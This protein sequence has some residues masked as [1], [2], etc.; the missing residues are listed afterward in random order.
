MDNYLILF[1][2]LVS[3][4]CQNRSSEQ[5]TDNVTDTRSTTVTTTTPSVTPDTLCYQQ[6]LDRDTTTLR[7]LLDGKLATGYLDVNPYQ[8]DRARGPLHGAVDANRIRVEWLRSGEGITQPYE[9]NLVQEGD[10]LSWWEG[11]FIERQGT[12]VLKEPGTGYQ[13]KLTKAE[14]SPTE[15]P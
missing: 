5:A 3:W 14:C 4:G 2:L 6:V 9:L 10:T 12:W 15:L 7:L 1:L 11:E 8:K 13:Y